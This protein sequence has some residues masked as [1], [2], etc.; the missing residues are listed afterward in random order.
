MVSLGIIV[1]NCYMSAQK[2]NFYYFLFLLIK[3]Q[4]KILIANNKNVSHIVSSFSTFFLEV[5][6]SSVFVLR[7]QLINIYENQHSRDKKHEGP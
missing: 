7:S 5:R 3:N 1:R 2:N 4:K 6:G